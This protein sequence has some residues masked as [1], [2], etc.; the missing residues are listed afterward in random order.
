MIHRMETKCFV[1]SAFV[2]ALSVMLVTGTLTMAL[3]ETSSMEGSYPGLATG[4]LRSASIADL[5]PQ[6][7]LWPE[8]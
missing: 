7:C 4:L 2:G 8:R 6:T 5:P 1:F 3:S